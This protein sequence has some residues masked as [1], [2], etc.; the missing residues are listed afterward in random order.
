MNTTKPITAFT[1]DYDFLSM[2]YPCRVVF[3]GLVYP[4]ASH[5]FQ[6][7]KTND[8]NRREIIRNVLD[9][10]TARSLGSHLKPDYQWVS[11]RLSI[12]TTVLENK[13]FNNIDLAKRLLE[14]GERYIAY[15]NYTDRVLGCTPAT[16]TGG[17]H[18]GIALMKIR[19]DIRTATERAKDA[20]LSRISFS[21][22]TGS[23]S[24]NALVSPPENIGLTQPTE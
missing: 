19:S 21:G 17:N 11:S 16:Y 2:D 23:N 15:A 10:A 8:P 20:R 3:D 4:S 9:G 5:A 13:F 22:G 14:T 18:L 1:G 24:G 6:A 7:S 12:L